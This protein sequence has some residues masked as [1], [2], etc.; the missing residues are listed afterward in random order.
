VDQSRDILVK[1]AKQFDGKDRT[2]LEAFG[3]GATGKEAEVYDVIHKELGAPAEKW[4]DA[5]SWLAWRLHV[6]A[7]VAD[8]KTRALDDKLSEA[9]RKLA[10]DAL[11]FVQSPE[12]PQAMVDIATTETFPLKENVTWWLNSRRGNNWK[13][14]GLTKLMRQRGLLK[15]TPLVSTQT[16]EVPEGAA[17]APTN[18]EVLALTGDVQRGQTA[19]ATCFTCHKVGKQGADFGPELTQ[20]GKTQPREV[21][22]D[23]I[24]HPSKEISH[25]YEGTRIETKDGI[26][27]DG[28]VLTTGDPT[29]VKC[30]GGQRQEIDEE[31]IKST[32]KMG[33]SLMFP[34]EVLG[35]NA[36]TV[37]DIVAY[38][39][40]NEIK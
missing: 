35:L 37:A 36:Q 23:A 2:Y 22:V 38:L 11:A 24:L 40:S 6:P 32:T 27:I 12:A 20:F 33:R 18:E 15:E 21:I 30:V 4:S 16:P 26:I 1:I 29:V 7:E 5:F 3:T 39:K 10:M 28:I 8:L 34:P 14:Y 9:Q 17:K 19:I 13:E 31:R 25:G